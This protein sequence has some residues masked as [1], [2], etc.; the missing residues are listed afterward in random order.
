MVIPLS[1]YF[2]IKP[3]C[4]EELGVLNAFIGID[5]KVF[6]DPNLLRSSKIPEF[7][8]AGAELEKYFAP[9]IKLLKASKAPND[10]AWEE[11]KKRLQFREEHGAALGYSGAGASGKGIGP[12]L[13]G[14]L[15]HRGKQIVEL[16]IEAPEMFELIGLF[17][18]NFGPDLLSDM[19]VAILKE[20]F[21]EYSQRVAT[22]LDLNPRKAFK[23]HGNE[24]LLP[25]HPDGKTAL[26]FVPAGL[27][28]PLPVALD[29]GEIDLVAQFNE[30]V[31]TQWNKIVAAAAKDDREPSK[32]EIRTVFMAAPKN[33]SDLIEVYKKAAGRGYDFQK[34]PKG[35]L[36]WDNIGRAAAQS[37]PLGIELNKP[38]TI[39]DLRQVLD[40]IIVQF[41]KNIE[42][43]R[44]YE[45]LYG[46]DGNPRNE[47]FSQRL[48]YAIADSYCAANNVDLSREP[49]AG[50]GPVDFKLSKGYHGRILVEVK[51]S[52]NSQ[53]LHGFE[54][55]LAEY[56]KA[57]AAE[58]AL[59][60]IL[61]VT[62]GESGINDVIALRE[63]ERS[64]GLKV[65]DIV[66]IDARKKLPASKA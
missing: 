11:A 32:A 57:E 37:F 23:F 5:N 34:D 1:I 6:V 15:V 52:S 49:N 61:R 3:A 7:E 45:V 43:N 55:Q 14:M 59:Y 25:V 46:E 35:L 8:N 64:K 17:Q 56:Q 19:A 60:L 33:L 24:W 10:V 40:L 54:T 16:G 20:S 42:E 51:K 9:I 50:N 38:K 48:F 12:L 65:P 2:K 39:A 62:Q 18:E 44:L 13:A 47:V 22:K 4:L 21:F 29:R 30:E 41:K 36:S 28:T 58:Q 53:L 26:I 27:L 63:R 66:V 31:R